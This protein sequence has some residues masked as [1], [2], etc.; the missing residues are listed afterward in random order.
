M[1]ISNL[2]E[3]LAVETIIGRYR[4]LLAKDDALEER[5]KRLSSPVPRRA[6]ICGIPCLCAVLVYFFVFERGLSRFFYLIF[7]AAILWDCLLRF[8]R[9]YAIVG[10]YGKA[11]G[12]VSAHHRMGPRRGARIKYSFLSADDKVHIG[13]V[14]GTAFLPKEGQT[15]AVLYKLEDP[16]INLPLA[17]FWFYRFPR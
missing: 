9:E 16:T 10:H 17:S 8:R 5:L 1:R 13:G 7:A 2:S 6:L 4:N 15:L 3:V 12:T 11:V 14:G